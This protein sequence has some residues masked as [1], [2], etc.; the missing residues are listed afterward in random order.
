[1]NIVRRALLLS[2]GER[3]I[4]IAFNFATIAAV[5]RILTPVE[6]GVSVICLAILGMAMSAREFASSSFIIQRPVLSRR[7]IR[8]AF[9]LMLTVSLGIAAFLVAAAPA[10]ASSFEEYELVPYL[11]LVSVCVVVDTVAIQVIALLR[12]EMA[13]GRVALINVSGAAAAGMTTVA[14]AL[15][16]FSYMSFAWAWLASSVVTSLLAVALWPHFWMFKPTFSQWRGMTAFGGYNGAMVLLSKGYE[17]LPPLLLGRLIS[18]GAA[19]LFSRGLTVCQ[20]P[21]KLILGGAMSVVLPAFSRSLREGSDPKQPYL[22]ALELITCLHWPALLALAALAYPTVDTLLGHQ[23]REAAPLVQIIAVAS[24]FSFSFELNYP[25]MVAMGSIKDMFLRTLIVVPVS[26]AVMATAVLSAGL[27][28]AA[29]SLMVIVPF[30]AFVSLSFVRR[31]LSIKW[32]EIAFAVR[33][34]AVVAGA[35]MVG[36]LAVLMANGFSF[37]LSLIQALFAGAL[38]AT[39]WICGLLVTRHPLLDE[40][41]NALRIFRQAATRE[42]FSF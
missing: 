31:R 2:S 34:S 22:G 27:H 24:L 42:R 17:A 6:I 26:I 40:M 41:V 8:G 33:R 15:A 4:T 29:L 5:S 32:R 18:P 3:Y 7:D 39:G 23:W 30:Q 1:M 11:R 10:L 35:S 28:G 19:A 36:S 16:G 25:V 14:L 37:Q 38:V 12:R 20:I 9:S 21:D 13:F